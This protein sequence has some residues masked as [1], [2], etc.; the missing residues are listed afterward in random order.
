MKVKITTYRDLD[1]WEEGL[2]GKMGSVVYYQLNGK[3]FIRNTASNYD[4]T[5][6]PKQTAARERFKQAQLFA[7]SIIS[8]PVLKAQY[9]ARTGA[10]CT[11]Y[12]TA[13][14]EWLKANS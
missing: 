13:I 8:D 2:S 6:T 3:T 11:A 10:K 12:A 7:I 5:P 14:S 9:Q 4:K 1:W